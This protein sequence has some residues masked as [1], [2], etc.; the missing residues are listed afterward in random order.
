M[1]TLER[2]YAQDKP[3]IEPAV[4]TIGQVAQLLQVSSRTLYRLRDA[5][6]LPQCVRIGGA[7]RWSRSVVED[8]VQGGCKPEQTTRIK[9]VTNGAC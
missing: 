9:G 1:N 4:L 3:K 7:I 8:W 5:G 2:A 6:K